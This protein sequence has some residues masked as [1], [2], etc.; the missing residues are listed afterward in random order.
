MGVG[1]DRRKEKGVVVTTA[2][3]DVESHNHTRTGEIINK[4]SL[5]SH[6]IVFRQF[7]NTNVHLLP[8][9]LE[10]RPMIVAVL[11]PL[12]NQMIFDNLMHF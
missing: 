3:A 1:R 5:L 11:V 2:C 10:T 6:H 7:S 4:D 9:S 8:F 12:V